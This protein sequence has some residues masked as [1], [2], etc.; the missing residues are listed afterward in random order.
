MQGTAGHNNNFDYEKA[1]AIVTVAML[2]GNKVATTEY[3]I[4][5]RTLY[6]YKAMFANDP[7]MA[8]LV[9]QKKALIDSELLHTISEM[10]TSVIQGIKR[11]ADQGHLTDPEILDSVSKA[12]VSINETYMQGKMLDVRLEQVKQI[13]EVTGP[14]V[15]APSRTQP[16][17]K[18]SE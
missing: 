16:A 3:Q 9:S 7:L 17:L 5:E 4:S 8:E 14:V 1:A 15:S 6:R 18:S 12:C 11:A 2:H 13:R 10:N